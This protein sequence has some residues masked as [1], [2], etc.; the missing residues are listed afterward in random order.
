MLDTPFYSQ[1]LTKAN[2]KLEGF[3]SL[4]DARAWTRRICGLACL[5]MVIAK[6]TGQSIPLKTLLDQGLS[7][8]GYM[9]GVGWIHQGLV[10]I[11]E[12]YGVTAQCQ[13]IGDQLEVVDA[14]INRGQ[15]V[16]ASVSCGFN[17]KKKGGHLV[18]VIGAEKDGFIIHHPS[19][20][21]NEQWPHHFI[22]KA[23]F[24]ECFSENGNIIMLSE[25][26]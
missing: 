23:Q 13:S 8:D 22:N 15:L 25:P 10:D 24:K 20:D 2:Y 16:I 5:K 11:A 6:K 19:S 18:L 26:C 17:Q 14:A 12:Q 3:K 4:K 7:V 21:K 1:R 9:Q